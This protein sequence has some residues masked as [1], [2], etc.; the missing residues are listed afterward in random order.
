MDCGWARKERN[1][2]GIF[3]L[4]CWPGH[5]ICIE[6]I[7]LLI[8]KLDRLAP[9]KSCRTE[10][11]IP[12]FRRNERFSVAA[13]CCPEPPAREDALFKSGFLSLAEMKKG[14]TMI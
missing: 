1:S 13:V 6:V 11:C 10:P 8:I 14:L 12:F 5:D 9:V 2:S 7:R 4:D 3:N